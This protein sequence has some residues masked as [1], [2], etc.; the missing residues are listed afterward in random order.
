MIKRE[1]NGGMALYWSCEPSSLSFLLFFPRG[2]KVQSTDSLASSCQSAET[3]PASII[4][5][6]ERS[7]PS[8]NLVLKIGTS[9]LTWKTF[10]SQFVS[11]EPNFREMSHQLNQLQWHTEK[12]TPSQQCDACGHIS[13]FSFVQRSAVMVIRRLQQQRQTASAAGSDTMAAGWR[14]AAD[15]TEWFINITDDII[16]M[17]AGVLKSCFTSVFVDYSLSW[18]TGSKHVVLCWKSALGFI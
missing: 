8:E 3:L 13:R 11:A 18:T 1:T 12:P 7:Q 5:C 17:T 10:T 16:I 9:S 2:I 14:P 6:Q 15:I 4:T